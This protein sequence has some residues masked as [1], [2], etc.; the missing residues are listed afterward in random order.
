MKETF[1]VIAYM[2]IWV[3]LSGYVFLLAQKQ[4]RLAER[5]DILNKR[6]TRRED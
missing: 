1:L 4:R 6:L 2:A 5:L 3:G